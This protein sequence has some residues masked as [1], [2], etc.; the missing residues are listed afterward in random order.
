MAR[1]LQPAR[2]VRP[3]GENAEIQAKRLGSASADVVRGAAA[4]LYADEQLVFGQVNAHR[5]RALADRIDAGEA[6]VTIPHAPT[7]GR[8]A[9]VLETLQARIDAAKAVRCDYCDKTGSAEPC[10]MDSPSQ[11]I[12]F[13]VDEVKELASC[14]AEFDKALGMTMDSVDQWKATAQA[15]SNLREDE[16]RNHDGLHATLSQLAAD[17]E[18]AD[19]ASPGIEQRLVFAFVMDDDPSAAGVEMATELALALLAEVE[20]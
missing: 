5:L 14:L 17:V 13:T 3:T 9:E 8:V 16:A 15:I 6:L 1:T 7:P 18:R 4:I 10:V 2:L 11:P 19:A 12:A 20:G